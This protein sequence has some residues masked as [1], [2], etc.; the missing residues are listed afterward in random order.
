MSN[1]TAEQLELLNTEFPADMEKAAAAQAALISDLYST[2]FTKIAAQAADE[3]DKE[4]KKEEEKEEKKELS[5]EHEKEASDR[6]AFIARG[7]IDGLMKEGS[8][9]HG[10]ELHYLMPFIAEKLAMDAGKV[11]AFLS[12]LG[13][14]AKANMGTVGAKMKAG[15]GTAG[16]QAKDLAGKAKDLANKNPGKAMAAAGT[17]GLLAGYGAGSRKKDN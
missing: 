5:E 4:E 2:G 14:K 8:E 15:A 12:N 10:D 3:M 13:S 6:G 1:L 9:R 17:A 11:K 7:Y 16:A